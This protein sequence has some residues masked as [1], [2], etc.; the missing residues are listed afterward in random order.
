MVYNA[1]HFELAVDLL[2]AVCGA[3]R[4]CIASWRVLGQPVAGRVVAR[5]RWRN[6]LVVQL[7]DADV[8]FPAGCGIARGGNLQLCATLGSCLSR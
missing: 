5:R 1:R 6:R 2:I 8:G 4:S 7:G 3:G